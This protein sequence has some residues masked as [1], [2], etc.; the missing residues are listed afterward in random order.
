M[1]PA[2]SSPTMRV[3]CAAIGIAILVATY[4]IVS[5]GWFVILAVLLAYEGWTLT[6]NYEGDTISEMMWV[7]AKRPMVPCIFGMAAAW[8]V[9]TGYVTNPWVILLGGGLY[10]HFFFQKAE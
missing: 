7:L 1:L 4:N 9:A 6:N 2:T 10:G 5:L 8:A 3:V